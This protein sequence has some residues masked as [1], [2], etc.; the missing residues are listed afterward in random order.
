MFQQMQ[1]QHQQQ[2]SLQKGATGVTVSSASGIPTSA[3]GG[4][5]SSG[6]KSATTFTPTAVMKQMN[7]GNKSGGDERDEGAYSEDGMGNAKDSSGIPAGM[8]PITKGAVDA[9]RMQQQQ[10]QQQHQMQ[11]WKSEQS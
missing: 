5:G 2:Q 11:V 4:V 6:Q 1:K 9:V 10:Q 3:A 7:K 8:R